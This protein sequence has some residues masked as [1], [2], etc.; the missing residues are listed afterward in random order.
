MARPNPMFA[1]PGACVWCASTNALINKQTNI[2]YMCAQLCARPLVT[3]QYEYV[4]ILLCICI[5]TTCGREN[6]HL[7]CRPDK[8]RNVYVH[9]WCAALALLYLPFQSIKIINIETGIERRDTGQREAQHR[10]SSRANCSDRT[11]IG[12]QKSDACRINIWAN[13]V[14]PFYSKCARDLHHEMHSSQWSP[15][16]LTQFLYF[17]NRWS[18]HFAYSVWVSITFSIRTAKSLIFA[19]MRAIDFF[20]LILSHFSV[21]KSARTVHKMTNRWNV[22]TRT[23]AKK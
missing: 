5:T 4:C 22:K 12:C 8:T 7:V 14:N 15:M 21:S 20:L 17:Q 11:K 23:A 1:T 6:P 9:S 16:S 10:N 3:V 19:L 13:P 18:V 2:S